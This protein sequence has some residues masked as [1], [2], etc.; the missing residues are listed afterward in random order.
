M[1]VLLPLPS[2]EALEPSGKEVDSSKADAAYLYAAHDQAPYTRME[3]ILLHAFALAPRI[4]TP[5]L[6]GPRMERVYEVRSYESATEKSFAN[7]VHMFNEGGEI[8]LFRRL[9][10]NAIFY[11]EVVA[12]SKMPNLMYLTSF[13]NKADR[14]AHWE[15]FG[16]DPEWKKLSSMPFY[17]YNVSHIDIHFLRPTI[18]SDY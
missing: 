14:D 4:E 16:K 12:G 6:N 5:K 13:E 8:E 17:Q 7:K 3:T 18:Y 11:G 9:Q 10:F 15:S 1:Y 2:L